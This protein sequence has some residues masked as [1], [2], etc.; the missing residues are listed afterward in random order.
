[1]NVLTTL[2]LFIQIN[3]VVRP[4]IQGQMFLVLPFHRVWYDGRLAGTIASFSSEAEHRILLQQA[5]AS[6][7]PFRV[8]A[9]WRLRSTPLGAT[10]LEW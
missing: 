10:F 4:K 5:F 9:G 1:M 6:S 7:D 3:T 2:Y 8:D